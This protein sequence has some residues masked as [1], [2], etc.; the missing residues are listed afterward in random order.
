MT[1]SDSPA[2]SSSRPT[3]AISTSA[4]GSR[5]ARRSSTASRRYRRSRRGRRTCRSSG[6][7]R[8]TQ[9]SVGAVSHRRSLRVASPEGA[10]VDGLDPEA[11]A[12]LRRLVRGANQRTRPRSRSPGGDPRRPVRQPIRTARMPTSSEVVAKS[13]AERGRDRVVSRPRGR[14]APMATSPAPGRGAGTCGSASAAAITEASAET[15]GHTPRT[16]SS[17]ASRAVVGSRRHR[18]RLRGMTVRVPE[19]R[20]VSQRWSGE[21]GAP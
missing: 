2:R 18:N 5:R 14:T 1:R 13:G 12:A 6:T 4:A 15:A 21:E 17:R 9:D 16:A 10:V 8:R 20:K 19:C 11:V 7:R 3:T